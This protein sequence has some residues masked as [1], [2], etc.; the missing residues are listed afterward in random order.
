MSGTTE[1][2]QGLP[3]HINDQVMVENVHFLC[4]VFQEKAVAN[5]VKANVVFNLRKPQPTYH[6]R[7]QPQAAPTFKKGNNVSGHF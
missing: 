6:A 4:R 7:I 1:E 2:Q 5:G 3:T